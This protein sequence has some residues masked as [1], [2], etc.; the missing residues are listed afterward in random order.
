MSLRTTVRFNAISAISS[1]LSHKNYF[2]LERKVLQFELSPDLLFK[3][4]DQA[5]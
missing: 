2:K 3:R 1:T 5:A 4:Q